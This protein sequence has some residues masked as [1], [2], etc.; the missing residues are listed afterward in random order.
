MT[1]PTDI[2]ALEAL[3]KAAIIN[4]DPND[5]PLEGAVGWDRAEDNRFVA[6]LSPSTVLALIAELRQE[7]ERADEAERDRDEFLAQRNEYIGFEQKAQADLARARETIEKVR[8]CLEEN[9]DRDTVALGILATYDRQNGADD[10]GSVMTRCTVPCPGAS[11]DLCHGGRCVIEAGH[12]GS[13]EWHHPP[14]SAA[15]VEIESHRER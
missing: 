7:R 5:W 1:E 4:D 10:W 15:D 6:T 8:E 2:D 9:E 13:H 3:A 12:P 14:Q 11:R